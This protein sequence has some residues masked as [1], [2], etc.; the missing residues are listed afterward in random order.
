MARVYIADAR[1]VSAADFHRMFEP[2]R[3]PLEELCAQW[4][5]AAFTDG[6]ME[7]AHEL[8]K[9]IQSLSILELEAKRNDDGSYSVAA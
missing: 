1:K 6:D 9:R 8:K 4:W 5:Q 2:R 3:S 7:R